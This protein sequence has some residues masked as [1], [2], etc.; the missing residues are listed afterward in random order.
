MLCYPLWSPRPTHILLQLKLKKMPSSLRRSNTSTNRLRISYISSMTSKIRAMINTGCHII[1]KW[2]I[3]FGCNCRNNA[4]HDP[5]WKLHPLH[6]GSYTITKVVGDNSFEISI[7][8]FLGLH[9]V[10]NVD[11]YRPY[12]PP[13]LDTSKITEQLT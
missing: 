8:H 9:L 11:L 12:F 6:Y 3:K 10:F 7:P 4:L 2:E 1:F 5:H 13:L